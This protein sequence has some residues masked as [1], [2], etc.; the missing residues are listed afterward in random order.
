MVD[1][2]EIEKQLGNRIQENISSVLRLANMF[3]DLEGLQLGGEFEK[4]L[5][6]GET[7]KVRYELRLMTE[8]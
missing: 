6:N 5:P 7:K 3:V 1:K 2:A 8:E 4:N